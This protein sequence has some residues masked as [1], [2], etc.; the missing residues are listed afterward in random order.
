MSRWN[1]GDIPEWE[2]DEDTDRD[3]EIAEEMERRAGEP[4]KTARQKLEELREEKELNNE[5]W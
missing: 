3:V 1:V 2:P 5:P 4:R